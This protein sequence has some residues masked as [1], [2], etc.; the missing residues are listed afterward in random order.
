MHA[1]DEYKKLFVDLNLTELSVKDGEFELSLKAKEKDM[2]QEASK[3]KAFAAPTEET[4]EEASH[5]YAVKSPL[6]GVFYAGESPNAKVYVNVGDQ[7]KK[8]DILCTIETMKMFNDVT[9][10]V[11]GIVKQICVNNG[12]L[13]EYHQDLFLIDE[14]KEDVNE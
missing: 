8:G 14:M 2:N 4:K 1:L 9:S 5:L 13:V 7:V 12:E 3:S 10:K 11:D 6:L